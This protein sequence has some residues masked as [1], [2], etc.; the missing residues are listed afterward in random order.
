MTETWIPETTTL[1][2]ILAVTP[3][4]QTKKQGQH[5]GALQF[6]RLVRHP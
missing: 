2:L 5:Q 1:S 3:F 6:S 4:C